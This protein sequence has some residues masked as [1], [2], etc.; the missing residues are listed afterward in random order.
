MGHVALIPDIYYRAGEWA[1]FDMAITE[2]ASNP[3]PPEGFHRGDCH[4]LR[5]G[6]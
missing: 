2:L 1:P 5:A 6:P 3:Q 4:R